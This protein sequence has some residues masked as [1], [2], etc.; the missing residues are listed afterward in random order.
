V[1]L[2]SKHWQLNAQ[3]S[4]MKSG[5]VPKSKLI[6]ERTLLRTYDVLL[7]NRVRRQFENA[8]PIL[9]SHVIG[10]T[11]ILRVD[12]TTV[13]TMLHIRQADDDVWTATYGDGR[14]FITYWVIETQR[15]IVVV[16][17][18]WAG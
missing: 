11:A 1:T 3:P 6:R 18:I 4:L 16:D 8:P 17:W 14:G 10:I 13:S 5:G 2:C 12:P 9:E 15:L 7:S